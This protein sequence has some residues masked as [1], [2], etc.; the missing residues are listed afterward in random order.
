MPVTGGESRKRMLQSGI[1]RRK[2][3]KRKEGQSETP[4]EEIPAEAGQETSAASPPSSVGDEPMIE[5]NPEE[6]LQDTEL[7][8]GFIDESMEHLE[9]IE[10]NV[11]ELEHNPDDLEI[12]NNIF[13]PFHTIKGVSGFLNLK[14]INTL[15]HSV[16]NLL[17][18]VRNG[19]HPMD[20]AVIDIVLG[21]GDFLRSMI[22]NIREVL[23]GGAEK[24][25]SFDIRDY[26]RRIKEI[27]GGAR[28]RR[29]PRFRKRLRPRQKAARGTGL[30]TRP[31]EGEPLES[32]RRRGRGAGS[33]PETGS[34][35]RPRPAE[36]K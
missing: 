10:A 25:K 30:S 29:V 5:Q 1:P 27:Q 22:E 6:F 34:L 8:S 33:R 28:F 16:E 13:R 4:V 36:A 14:A 7:L 21:V 2:R 12:I 24:F 26:T 19:I 18:D 35:P 17:D 23:E 32:R 20:S 3:K 15:A 9:T 31:M 11:L